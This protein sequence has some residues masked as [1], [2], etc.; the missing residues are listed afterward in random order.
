MV[1]SPK[2]PDPYATAAAQT[3]S[4]IGTASAN[5]MI[6]NANEN[7]P[8]GSVNYSQTGTGYIT[9][10]KGTKTAVPTYTRNVTLSPDEQQL[11]DK[12]NQMQQNLAD[13]GVQQTGKIGGLLNTSLNTQGLPDWQNYASAPGLKTT[14]AGAEDTQN[15]YSAD[16]DKVTNALM[17]RYNAINDP[18]NAAQEV[19]LAARGLSPGSQNWG[20][21]QD[22]QGRS[23]NDAATQ[24]ILAGGQEQSRMLTD[25][26]NAA[27]FYNTAATQGFQ[28][29]NV[30]TANANNLRGSEL[31]E[32]QNLRTE[33]LNEI[34]AL[35]S[36]SQVSVPQFQPYNAPSVAGTPI[37]QYIQDNYNA[38]VQQANATNTGLFGLGSALV[39]GL[40]GTGGLFSSA[41][42]GTA[43]LAGLL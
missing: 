18:V 43:A 5:A 38:K 34:S 26:Y 16:R 40:T 3:Q 4:N 25:A 10:S 14:Y 31:T 36:G 37:G 19:S 27:N 35:M 39:G 8:Y 30:A 7:N 2:P 17:T 13:I 33:P 29:Q 11:F 6:G 1:S 9:D 42:A 41:G 24:A 21:V 32:R 15:A 20:S 28:N 22:A 12:Q 23:R